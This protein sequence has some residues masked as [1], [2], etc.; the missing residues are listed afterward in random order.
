MCLLV[1]QIV[2]WRH[3][4]G[5]CVD[6]A[7]VAIYPELDGQ[8]MPELVQHTLAWTGVLRDACSPSLV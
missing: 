6:G 7:G 4:L 1:L 2:G 8:N 3:M 5:L